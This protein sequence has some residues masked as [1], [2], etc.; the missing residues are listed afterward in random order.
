MLITCNAEVLKKRCVVDTGV[1]LI[2]MKTIILDDCHFFKNCVD[3][4]DLSRILD[5]TQTFE[6]MKVDVKPASFVTLSIMNTCEVNLCF[7]VT[8]SVRV[9]TVATRLDE[10]TSGPSGCVY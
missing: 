6:N 4:E 5:D 9:N 7:L 10:M 1:Y 2:V 8:R 3:V